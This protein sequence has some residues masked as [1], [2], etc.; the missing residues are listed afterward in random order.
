MVTSTLDAIAP[1]FKQ[2]PQRGEVVAGYRITSGYGPRL[3][4]CAGC[5]QFHAGV[6]AGTPIGTPVYAVGQQGET[7]K[8]NCFWDTGGGGLV[9]NVTTPR[10][11][12]LTLQYLHL[13]RCSAGQQPAGSVIARTGRSGLGTGPH[14]DFR[15][16]QSGQRI[17]PW[18]G[19]LWWSLTGQPPQPLASRNSPP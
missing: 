6:D 14:L 15:L 11:P 2:V 16:K 9:A 19:L 5:S 12:N 8:V 1:D 10:F 17:P 3:R 18:R 13:S 4:P 7:V